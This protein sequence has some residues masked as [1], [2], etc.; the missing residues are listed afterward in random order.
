[1]S[2][3][4]RAPDARARHPHLR[5]DAPPGWVRVD[6]HLHTWVS[7]DAVTTLDQLEG[8]VEE[9]AIDVVCIT[10]HHELSAARSALERDMGVRVVVGEEIRTTEGELIG[11]FLGE[12]IPYVLPVEEV[13]RRIR[14]QGGLVY[15]PHP[16]DPRR[17]ALDETSLRRLASQGLVDVV[18][19]L[20]A[21]VGDPALLETAARLAADMDLP[22]AAGSDAHDPEGIG[23]AYVELPD[24]DG[25][26]E[27]LES[28]RGGRHRGHHFPHALRYTP[29]GRPG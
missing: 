25:P 14:A 9:C 17:R 12:R 10:D 7:G 1:M 4:D 28:L 21:K 8:A 5:E 26:R 19:T 2:A 23:A 20:N 27:L 29:A 11:L 15:V 6:F 16:L 22:T 3:D 13:A 18:E 24:F